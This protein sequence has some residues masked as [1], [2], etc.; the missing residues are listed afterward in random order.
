MDPQ[1]LLTVI[2]SMLLLVGV[3][4]GRLPVAECSECPHCLAARRRHQEEQERL[5][6]ELDERWRLK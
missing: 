1:Q 3:A 6:D 2:G 5:R 4:V